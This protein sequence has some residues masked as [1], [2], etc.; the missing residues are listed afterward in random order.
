MTTLYANGTRRQLPRPMVTG[1]TD[2]LAIVHRPRTTFDDGCLEAVSVV[3]R[4]GQPIYRVTGLRARV[5]CPE[6]L[7][8]R[9][10]AHRQ[11]W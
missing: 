1:C 7:A 3:Q 4:A 10:A 5:W 11:P 8:A 2:G 9:V 6:S